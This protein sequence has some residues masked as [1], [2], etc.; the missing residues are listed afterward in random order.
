M[1]DYANVKKYLKASWESH[2]KMSDID[3]HQAITREI[4][5]HLVLFTSG[6]IPELNQ[7]LQM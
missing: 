6:L 5:S 2:G 3:S 4:N 1:W 7:A